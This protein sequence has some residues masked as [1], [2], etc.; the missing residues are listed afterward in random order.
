M[1]KPRLQA[2]FWDIDDT[3]FTTTAFAR[4]ARERAIAAMIER[5]LRCSA[6]AVFDELQAVVEEFGSN[7]DRHYDRL[8]GRLPA[9]ATAGVNP[10]LLVMA[11]VI[12]YHET[13]WRELRLTEGTRA[14]L[15]DLSRTDVKLGVV[16]AGLTRKQMEKIL[17]LGMD[18]YLDPGLIFITDQVGVA[19]TNPEL[20]VMAA[21]AAGVEPGAAMHVGDHPLRDV[22][23]AKRAGLFATW[24][25]GSGKHA[26]LQPALPPD[27]SIEQVEELRPILV[28]QYGVDL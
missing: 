18:R 9:E 4:L 7:D 22:E 6:S 8:L 23:T 27:H 16:T 21:R 17:R 10:D 19:K 15:E 28:E 3:M 20:Y 12:A 26:H 14:L 24:H 5:G 25:R 2:L 13:K 1:S 11:G